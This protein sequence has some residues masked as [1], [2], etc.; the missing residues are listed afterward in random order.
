MGRDRSKHLCS[1]GKFTF[2]VRLKFQSTDLILSTNEELNKSF[3]LE[4]IDALKMDSKLPRRTMNL[5]FFGVLF[6]LLQIVA[7]LNR[8]LP[9]A[10]A[11]SDGVCVSPGGRF[12]PYSIQGKPPR[13]VSKGP[14]DL[15][16]CRVFRKKTCCDV[17]QTH[18]ALLAIRR[19]ASS[20]EASDECL[21][22]WELL[23]CS[24]CDPYVGVQSGSPTI[25]ASLCDR[26]YDACSNAYFAMDGKN[27]VL[28]PCGISDTVCGRASEWVSNGTELCKASGFSVKPSNDFKETFCYGGK[29]SLESVVDSWRTS[30]TRDVKSSG[31]LFD[32][33]QW[34]REMPINE[35]VSWA[36]GGL[37]LTAGLLFVSKRKSHNQRQ[38]QA[39]IQRT[40]RKLGGKTSPKYP[41]SQ[42]NR[43]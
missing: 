9:I 33:Q 35:Q 13:A 8:L 16:L 26:I 22:L 24:I 25:C 30:H 6:L 17:T 3:Q 15:T 12:P 37:V 21:H 4:I 32:F 38:R 29:S 42:A 1:W 20:G 31:F 41:A 7:C 27:Q 28:V 2:L 40:A 11:K 10:S 36:V 18:P 19:L 34:V 43:K 23:E 39:A 5:D 14:T